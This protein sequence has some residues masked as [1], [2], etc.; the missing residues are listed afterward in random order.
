MMFLHFSYFD[1][2]LLRSVVLFSKKDTILLLQLLYICLY[3]EMKDLAFHAS[4]FSYLIVFYSAE[5]KVLSSL[6]VI[7]NSGPVLLKQ[8]MVN[9][10]SFCKL[11]TTH[12]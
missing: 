5:L 6:T 4:V 3:K 11:P 2:Y 9:F 8:H 10:K 1:N 12:S 7:S